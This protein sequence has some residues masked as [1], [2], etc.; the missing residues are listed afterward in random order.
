MLDQTR[1][2]Y[3]FKMGPLREKLTSA[4]NKTTGTPNIPYPGR[5]KS[6]TTVMLTTL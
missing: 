2:K 5:D 3:G 4:T 6:K 1:E